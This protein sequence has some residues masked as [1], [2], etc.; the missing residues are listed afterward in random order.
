METSRKKKMK[1]EW[2][3]PEENAFSNGKGATTG[4]WKSGKCST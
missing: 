4:V 2:K 3:M 1:E